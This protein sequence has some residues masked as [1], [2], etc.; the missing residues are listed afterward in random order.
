MLSF[1]ITAYRPLNGKLMPGKADVRVSIRLQHVVWPRPYLGLAAMRPI[2]AIGK[3]FV[4]S[5]GANTAYYGASRTL[6]ANVELDL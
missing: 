6:Q 3:A 4:G 1:Q 2:T 5:T